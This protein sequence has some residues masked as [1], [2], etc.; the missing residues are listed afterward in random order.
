MISM[1]TMT[2][3]SNSRRVVL[4]AKTRIA[5]AAEAVREI[6]DF[7]VRAEVKVETGV[8]NVDMQV[9]VKTMMVTEREMKKMRRMRRKMNLLKMSRE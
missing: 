5:V 8:N 9:Q 2:M 4:L 7:G 1:E 3:I 6:E